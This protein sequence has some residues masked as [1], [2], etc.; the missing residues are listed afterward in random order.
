MLSAL[1][2]VR[3]RLSRG[4]ASSVVII[5]Q[6]VAKL[7]VHGYALQLWRTLLADIMVNISVRTSS[8]GA[9]LSERP[10]LSSEYYSGV[11]ELLLR[12]AV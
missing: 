8:N 3:D 11:S 7:C 6:L 2:T 12:S 4:L 9:D 5:S 10:V 1:H